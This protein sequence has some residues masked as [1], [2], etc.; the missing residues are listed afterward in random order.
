[1]IKKPHVKSFRMD[2][3]T[4]EKV[5]H[6]YGPDR[7]LKS[8]SQFVREGIELRLKQED[9]YIGWSVSRHEKT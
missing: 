8:F 4:K 2:D 3:T 9:P 7:R 1:M 6:R 5:R